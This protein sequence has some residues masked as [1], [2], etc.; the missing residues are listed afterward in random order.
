MFA[1]RTHPSAGSRIIKPDYA[2]TVSQVFTQLTV[3]LIQS[4]KNLRVLSAVHHDESTKD[5][6]FPSW[7]PALHKAPLVN[8]L[9]IDKKLYYTAD[10]GIPVA[11][12]T[13]L[14]ATSDEVL[15]VCGFVFDTIHAYPP[16]SPFHDHEDASSIESDKLADFKEAF[17]FCQFEGA[18]EDEK[19]LE[20]FSL[21]IAAGL[22]DGT[23]AEMAITEHRANFSAFLIGEY[24]MD[25]RSDWTLPL[26]LNPKL[27]DKLRNDSVKGDKAKFMRDGNV[28]W[29][30]RRFFRTA[31]GYFG[32]GPQ[33]L[34]EGD[35]CCVLFGA[36]VPFILRE[37]DRGYVLVGEC[38][39]QG[40]MHG[41]AVEMWRK[42]DS[43]VAEFELH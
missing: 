22:V 15:K 6:E 43:E 30:Y 18:Y 20:A 37:V 26:T 23:S 39:V 8:P 27:L 1:L 10:S 2:K 41:E 33:Y 3:G 32:L 4:S 31:Q 34:M 19:R 38:Y 17:T 14:Q 42:G 11:D 9:G 25:P 7:V 36:K 35:L 21:T 12:A 16:S 5:E 29:R 24:D 40:I 13:I 28:F